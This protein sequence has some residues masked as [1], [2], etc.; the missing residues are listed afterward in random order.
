[1]TRFVWT[2]AAVALG[3]L[4]GCAKDHPPGASAPENGI[5][6]VNS[7]D[8]NRPESPSSA[9]DDLYFFGIIKSDPTVDH[10]TLLP[11][12]ESP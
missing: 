3:L 7:L 4:C 2:I 10:E 11:A 1:M 5:F 6:I 12:P 8:P 9:L